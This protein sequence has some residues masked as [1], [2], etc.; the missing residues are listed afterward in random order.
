MSAVTC[1]CVDKSGTVTNNRLEL[2]DVLTANEE[3]MTNVSVL[4]C[5]KGESAD[6]VDKA[7]I[8]NAAFRGAD[9]R[10]LQENELLREYPFDAAETAMGNL[11]SVNGARLLCVKGAPDRL[12][13]L[14]DVP[15]D[16][17]YTV[18]NKI[19]SFEKQGYLVLAAA[20]ATLGAEDAPPESVSEVRYSFMG[21]LAF[22]NKTRD[23]IPFAVKSCYKAGIR[24][25]M[26]TGDSAESAS[27]IA[28]KIGLRDLN[29]ITGEQ[30]RAAEESGAAPDLAG[31][32]LFARVTPDQKPA[33]LRLLQE[34]GE[35]VAVSANGD[36]D[37]DLLEQ[38]DFGISLSGAGTGAAEKRR[39]L[40]L[41]TIILKRW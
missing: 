3:M 37:S 33:I 31:V 32:G 2:A 7:I 18:Q 39:S 21:L 10:E 1:I 20:F 24:V 40:R 25:V 6:N 22:E 17:L 5:A 9:V 13:P 11:W 19:V 28:A 26:M 29:V 35:V 30:L 15:T 38:A 12:L 23:N 14:C 41:R 27:A 4:A 34:S 16:M 8:L 36:P